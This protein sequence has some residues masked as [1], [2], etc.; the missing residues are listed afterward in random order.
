VFSE[1][2]E[3]YLGQLLGSGQV[4]LKY[5]IR[6]DA[7]AD[8]QAINGTP[9]AQLVAIAPLVSD[10]FD[11]DNAKVYDLIKQLVLE[12]PGQTYI[13]RFDTDADGRGAWNALRAHFEGDGFQNSNV[14]NANNT[15]ESLVYEGK[16]KG[17]TFEKLARRHLECYLEL[18]RFNET[19]QE[20][21]KVH[22]L[23]NY[24]PQSYLPLNS[25]LRQLQTYPIVLK[26]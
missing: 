24:R 18:A 20:T 15:L 11:R 21:R 26:K 10:S 19:I 13:M 12:G 3:T 25:K 4:P 7:I 14:E 16:K 22:D 8:P 2:M 17:F 6:T 9:Q 23:L 5:V 1:A